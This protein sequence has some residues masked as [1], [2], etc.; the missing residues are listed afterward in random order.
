M[1]T[2][3]PSST[4]MSWARATVARVHHLREGAA[5]GVWVSVEA[6]VMRASLYETD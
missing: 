6:E 5:A 1:F 2:T 3:V 4:T